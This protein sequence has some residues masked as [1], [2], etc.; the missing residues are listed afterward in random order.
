MSI[1]KLLVPTFATAALLIGCAGTYLVAPLPSYSGSDAG[2]LYIARPPGALD[3]MGGIHIAIDGAEIGTIGP[4][5][6]W[7]LSVSPGMHS[8]AIRTGG[9]GVLVPPRGVRCVTVGT[10]AATSG[11]F[12]A[13]YYIRPSEHCPPPKSWKLAAQSDR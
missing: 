8:V 6:Y 2:I 10:S 11:L 13:G 1:R 3:A 5:Q 12:E 9:I 7:R 4:G